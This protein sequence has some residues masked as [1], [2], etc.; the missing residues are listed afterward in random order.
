MCN[1]CE[2]L[3][4]RTFT[5]V[6][7]SAATLAL[8]GIVAKPSFAKLPEF[9]MPGELRPSFEKAKWVTAKNQTDLDTYLHGPI[10][11]IAYHHEGF[12]DGKQSLFDIA[13]PK[14]VSQSA[15]QR[16]YIMHNDHVKKRYGMIAYHY[17]VSPS[18]E[19]VKG[20]PLKYAPATGSTDPK[21]GEI[22]NFDGH[23]AVVAMADFDFE[24]VSDR[25]KQIL[26]L[27][28][29]ISA[30][31]RSF[32]VPSEDIRPHKDHVAFQ[33]E[34]GSSCPGKN[35]YAIRDKVRKMTLAISL[36]SVLSNRGYYKG[37][38]DGVFGP[39]SE[40]ALAT[41]SAANKDIGPLSF[42]DATLWSLLDNPN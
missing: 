34:F 21:T 41:F 38:L 22:A 8:A 7:L 14:K 15:V 18:G 23:F 39:V 35:L 32:R 2:K 3:S 30:A 12:A 40:K 17:A 27:I 37:S 31:Q 6:G 36:Q 42:S 16:T 25:E 1:S 20:R 4:R 26:S 33:G 10:K 11:Y 9:T 5:K 13:Q 24:L 19:I 29:V 28:T